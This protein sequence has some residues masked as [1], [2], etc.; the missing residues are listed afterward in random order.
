MLKMKMIRLLTAA[1]VCAALCCGMCFAQTVPEECLPGTY[2]FGCFAFDIPLATGLT[3]DGVYTTRNGSYRVTAMRLDAPAADETTASAAA[4]ALYGSGISLE[5]GENGVYS[6]SATDGYDFYR[7]YVKDET[8]LMAR[9]SVLHNLTL[10]DKHIAVLDEPVWGDEADAPVQADP[11]L[12]AQYLPFGTSASSVGHDL[13]TWKTAL[14]SMLSSGEYGIF[15]DQPQYADETHDAVT[16]FITALNRTVTI[17]YTR[18][19]EQVESIQWFAFLSTASE[20]IDL[21][22]ATMTSCETGAAIVTAMYFAD[23]DLDGAKM[24]ANIAALQN[25][26][27]NLQSWMNAIATDTLLVPPLLESSTMFFGREFSLRIV[28]DPVHGH[29]VEG[30]IRLADQ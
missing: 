17:V 29:R 23:M 22:N 9:C 13:T 4:Q 7:I 1:L 21:Y 20:S 10:F 11:A 15:W 28:T 5:L 8:A 6:A 16:G 14:E 25:G 12:V 3:E 26:F 24:S 27:T 19:G 18:E 30:C 2:A